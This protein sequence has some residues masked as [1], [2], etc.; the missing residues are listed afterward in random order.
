MAHIAKKKTEGEKEINLFAILQVF[1]IQAT[2]SAL[3]DGLKSASLQFTK[4]FYLSSVSQYP[5]NLTFSDGTKL[6]PTLTE[7]E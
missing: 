1:T 7:A 6:V 3:A 2:C 5:H 4:H